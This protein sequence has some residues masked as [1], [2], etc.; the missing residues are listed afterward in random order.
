MRL[1]T[2]LSQNQDLKQFDSKS[3]LEEPTEL[4]SGESLGVMLSCP[5]GLSKQELQYWIEFRVPELS[6]HTFKMIKWIYI[7]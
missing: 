4:E 1:A 2:W 6:Q 7:E 5:K 3:S